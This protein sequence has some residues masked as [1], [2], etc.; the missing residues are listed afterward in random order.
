MHTPAHRLLVSLAAAMLCALAVPTLPVQA[1]KPTANTARET[2]A[3]ALVEGA[4][5]LPP[6]PAGFAWKVVPTIALAFL[7]PDGWHLKEETNELVRIFSITKDEFNAEGTFQTGTTVL[8][9]RHRDQDSARFARQRIDSLLK[10]GTTLKAEGP[11]LREDAKLIAYE[12]FLT[13]HYPYR[14]ARV[15]D[16]YVYNKALVNK[17]THALYFVVFESPIDTWASEWPIG[18]QMMR[19]MPLDMEPER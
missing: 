3:S 12:L 19:I 4:H 18:E 14:D 8:A 10:L 2:S 6:A 11:W 17:G 15:R 5:K 16:K 9:F 7:V 1:A 13:A